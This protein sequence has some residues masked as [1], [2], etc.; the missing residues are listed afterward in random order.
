M[1]VADFHFDLPEALIARHPLAER[2]AS[3]LL[4]LDG[5]SGALSHRHFADLLE[6]LRPG[7]LMVFNNTRVI[8]AR[9]FGQKESGGKLEILVERV[10]DRRRVLAHVRSSKSPKP[11]SK[12]LI[13]GGAEAQMLQRHDALFE[14]GFA[15]D[16]LPLLERVG[17][18]PLPPYIDRP[19]EAADRERYQTVYAERAGAVAAPTAG[20][21]FDEGLLAA[22][23][24]KG[25][26]TAF[27]TLHVGAGTFQPVRVEKIEDHHMHSEWLEVGQDVVDA[28]AACRARGGRVIAVGTTS[29]RSLESAARDGQL[30]PFSGD[31]D[32]FLYPG[33]PFHVVDALV[34]NF[35][36]PESTLLMLVS[37][38]A[39]YPQT[40]AAYAAAVEHEYRFFSY[41]D[42][43]FITRNPAP[44]GPED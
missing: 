10:L 6:Y 34:T 31:T 21:H 36:L 27:V 32:I 37:A 8:P 1:R 7:D 23:R 43:M 39:G 17:H 28:V 4:V 40:M 33:R 11:G 13:D 3:R 24:E 5:P 22:I 19:D 26:D 35:H 25:V 29:V 12:I 9:L 20:L 41:G 16:V 30:K 44:R 18:M 15:E 2:R 38:F 14:L 42:A